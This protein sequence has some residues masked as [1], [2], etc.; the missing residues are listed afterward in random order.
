MDQLEQE[1]KAVVS[2]CDGK[3]RERD[4]LLNM[5]RDKENEIS[6][7][8]NAAIALNVTLTDQERDGRQTTI[9]S[10]SWPDTSRPRTTPDMTG[11]G[12]VMPPDVLSLRRAGTRPS[13]T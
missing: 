10:P 8:Q 1:R 13:K 11:K 9:S 4:E 5:I 3:K 12:R 6:R 7:Y 2:L